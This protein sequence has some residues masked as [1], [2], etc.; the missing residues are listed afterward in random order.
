MI[1]TRGVNLMRKMKAFLS[2]TLVMILTIALLAGCTSSSSSESKSSGSS[3]SKNITITMLVSGNKAAS[4]QDFEVDILPKLVHKKFPNITLE[5]QK[6]PDDQYT[7]SI[8]TKLAVNQA[9]DIFWV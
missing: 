7:T 1:K 8:K 5:V 9:P 4:G 2:G 3:N 6:L